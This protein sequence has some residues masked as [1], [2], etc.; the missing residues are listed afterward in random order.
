MFHRP[1]SDHVGSPQQIARTGRVVGFDADSATVEIAYG[2][3]EHGEVKTR[4]IAW[5]G[6]RA[7]ATSVW[8]PPTIGEQ[9]LLIAPEGDI[10]QAI[11]M[12]GLFS[13]QFPAPG[14]GIREFVR[15]GDT[16]EIGYDPEGH[17]FDIRL[18][19]GATAEIRA[20]GGVTIFGDI[21]VHGDVVADGVSLK[22]HLHDKVNAGSGVS[23]KPV[24]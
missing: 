8:S 16:A 9:V 17:H 3:D 10:A 1:A 19:E 15:F 4:S 13:G 7:G 22:D 18:P 23:G 6:M 24:R 11:A 20:T 12:P 14:N 5:G 2:D 21:T